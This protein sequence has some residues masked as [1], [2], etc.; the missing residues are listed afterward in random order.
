METTMQEE[1]KHRKQRTGIVISDKMDQTVSVLV[2]RTVTHSQFFKQI[3]RQSKFMA[4]NENN[5]AKMGDR[6]LIEESRPLSKLK[7]WRIV[8]IIERAK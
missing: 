7:R 6:V 8:E 1:L 4:H 3:K 5:D 2:E